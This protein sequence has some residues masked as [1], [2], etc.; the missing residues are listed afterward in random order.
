MC[1]FGPSTGRIVQ[2]CE[3]SDM[4]LATKTKS[5]PPAVGALAFAV[6][7]LG[8]ISGMALV[9]LD[10][11]LLG[12]IILTSTVATLAFLTVWTIRLKK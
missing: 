7:F 9:Q 5:L 1:G 12:A 8:I 3:S 4:R 10:E 6:A 2:A 11:A